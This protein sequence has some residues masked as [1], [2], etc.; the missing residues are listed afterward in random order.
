MKVRS[1]SPSKDS[2]AHDNLGPHHWGP[3]LLPKTCHDIAHV[4]HTTPIRAELSNA[5]AIDPGITPANPPY[6]RSKLSTL[7]A[8]LATPPSSTR[9]SCGVRTWL[10]SLP[11]AD[12]N[13]ANDAFSSIQWKTTALAEV[14]KAQG[15]PGQ[16][17]IISKHRLG[18][19]SCL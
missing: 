9:R 16:I 2:E 5:P 19:C 1:T 8:A 13:A 10:D 17:N 7:A 18:R 12:Q 15:F 6:H 11:D 14:F 4:N 3:F